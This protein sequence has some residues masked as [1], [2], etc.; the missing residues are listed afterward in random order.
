M[1]R[2]SDPDRDAMIAQLVEKIQKQLEH[3]LPDDNATF[4]QIED[5][6]ARIGQEVAKQVQAKLVKKQSQKPAD[7]TIECSCGGQARY[8]GRQRRTLLSKQGELSFKRPYYYCARCHRGFTP[9]D[10]ALQL[11]A[12]T[13]SLGVREWIAHL[14]A[15]LPF[16]Q[17]VA[18]LS[19]LTP[20]TLSPD[21]AERV[22]VAV[23][24]RLQQAKQ[25]QAALH[26]ADQLPDRRTVCPRRLY[27][28]MDGLFTPLRDPWKRDKS[29]GELVCRYGE[30]KAGVIYETYQD[31][32]GKDSR[33]KTHAYVATLEGVEVF[34]PLVSTQ[35][36]LCGQHAAK[37][38]VVI[39]DGA[40]WIWQLAA[41]LFPKALQIVDFFH[42]CQH[43]SALAEA[44][45]SKDEQASHDWQVAR[46][47][48]LKTN[49]MPQVL[50][51]IASWQPRTKQGRKLRRT[52]YEYFL[53]NAER[54]RYQTY[55]QRG[56][57]IGS[58]VVEATCKRVVAQRLDQA[59]MHWRQETAEAIVTLRA[60]LLSS[61]P[62]DLR[63]FCR[64]Q[65]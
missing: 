26:K 1:S 44:R 19:R 23:G 46:Q 32:M 3:D 65:A 64:I 14:S 4:D 61:Y 35:A 41:K 36:H 24:R 16:E 38:L 21:T 56:Y 52:T 22:A 28:G 17:A 27:I 30:C 25:E 49:R 63:P 48:E 8:K 18:L 58:G 9:L 45:F 43:L 60:A 7:P 5:A 40:P 59:G 10:A 31:K 37:E 15:H 47:E 20:L 51:A 11:D 29:Q 62:P 53:S 50:A 39:G 13:T 6:A 55:L 34:G 54:M 57:H 2:K 12:A 33:V 42:A